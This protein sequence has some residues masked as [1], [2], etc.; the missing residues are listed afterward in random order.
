[1]SNVAPPSVATPAPQ[2]EDRSGLLA[3]LLA[4]T[5]WGLLPLY[6]RPLGH[7]PALQI[8][9]HRIVESCLL[10]FAWLAFKGQ[11]GAVRSALANPDTRKRL[12]AS[13]LMI[14]VN[15][16]VY[17][18]AVGNGHVVDASL[19]YFINPLVSV[20][21]GVM[22]LSERLNRA[23]WAAVALAACGV[24]YLTYATG[25]VPWIA[26]VLALTFGTYGLIRKVVAVDSVPGLAVETL[27]LLPLSL[28][29]LI[30]CEYQGTGAFGH[31]GRTV[32]ALLIGSG[33]VTALPLTL[34]AFGARRI[35]LSTVGLLQYVGPTLQFLGGVFVFR[36]PFPQSRLIGFVIIW[37]ALVIY[38]A[39]N[40]WRRRRVW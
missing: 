8:T 33:I 2:G 27:L 1:M 36:E 19:G 34:F 37:A 29:W 24:L 38:V 22:L 13:T 30:W 28:G 31:Q 7:V 35:R 20:L 21:M 17:V 4:F 15:W 40:L 11:L 16:L 26:L 5:I 9:S 3:A 25:R 23:Q 39:D 14:S 12:I 10:V 6:L 32:D 18:W